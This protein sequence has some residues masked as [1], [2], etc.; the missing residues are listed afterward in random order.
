MFSTLGKK[1]LMGITG[2]LLVSFLLVHCSINALIFIN[3]GGQL[4]NLAAHFMATNILIRT[5][6]IGLFVGILLHIIDAFVLTY[7]N[8]NARPVGYKKSNASANSTWYSRSM[9]LLGS[10]VLFFLIIHLAHFWVKSRFVGLAPVMID[11]A[12][13]ENL[14][15]V[16]VAVF[17][18]PLWVVVYVLSMI[19][20]AYHLMH[21]FSST[22]QSLGLS[23]SRYTPIIKVAG[24]LYA[25]VLPIVFAAM[26]VFIY[27]V[28]K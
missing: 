7:Q 4:F 22:F 25:V 14:Y 28:G 21:G 5:A 20:L 3:D 17:S 19:P 6:E 10:A 18:D 11:G 26:P 24:L 9:M 13:Y 27:I 2:L 16:M 1:Y 8:R 15:A 12:E 23:H